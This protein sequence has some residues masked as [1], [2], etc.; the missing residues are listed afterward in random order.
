LNR[1]ET[2]GTSSGALTRGLGKGMVAGLDSLRAQEPAL[3]AQGSIGPEQMTALRAAA[4]DTFRTSCPLG[5][6]C[7]LSNYPQEIQTFFDAWISQELADLER[8]ASLVSDQQQLDVMRL[9]AQQLSD[10]LN[11]AQSTARL[12][13]TIPQLV[14]DDIGT[15]LV[16]K[17]TDDLV[18][19]MVGELY[20]IVDLRV[21]SALK[22]FD[23]ALLNQLVGI[24]STHLDW[25]G[26][27]QTWSST[28]FNTSQDITSK[29]NL[30]MLDEPAPDD[31]IIMLGYPNPAGIDFITGAWPR[32][33]AQRYTALWNALNDPTQSTITLQML[34]SDI[35]SAAGGSDILPC[36]DATPV[37]TALDVY[38][39]RPGQFEDYSGMVI[40][41]KIGPNLEFP[42]VGLDKWYRLDNDDWLNQATDLQSGEATD[43]LTKF[44]AK[45]AATATPLYRVGNGLSP[46][47]TFTLSKAPLVNVVN[48]VVPPAVNA[49][50]LVF[51]VRVSSLVTSGLNLA[52]MCVPGGSS[53]LGSSPPSASGTPPP[54]GGGVQQPPAGP[55]PPGGGGNP[56][57]PGDP[58]PS[59]A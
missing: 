31:R 34:P 41:M 3:L 56:V 19:V 36:S 50:E 17:N 24:G 25:T 27:L 39:V 6:Q 47:T 15:L 14:V 42:S 48:N 4:Y 18:S 7:Q 44:T 49:T 52:P 16:Q 58:P 22:S 12:L 46:F 30:A 10:D 43:V 28:I 35:W 51:M 21:P 40:P 32:V 11:G 23:P 37:V 20:P 59:G 13:Q 57:T 8:K 54:G 2:L 9:Q 33:E 53:G 5:P 1:T 45:T 55:R 38:M 26:D 29:M